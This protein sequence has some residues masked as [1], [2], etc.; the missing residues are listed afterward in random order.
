M[1]KVLMTGGAGFVGH[2]VVEHILKNTDFEVVCLDRLDTSGTIARLQQVLENLPAE[3]GRVRFVFHDLK[4]EINEFVAGQLG[5]P[6]YILHLAAGSHVD[7]SIEDPMSFV[8][9]NVVGTT[10]L[11]NYARQLD[12]LDLFVNFST[13]EVFGPAPQGVKYKEWDRYNSTNP[14]SGSKAGQTEMGM[15]FANTYQLPL[16]TTFCMNIFGERQHPEKYIPMCINRVLKGESITVH[17]SKE[18]DPGK[19][20]YIHARNVA[21]AV[22]F[23]LDNFEQREKYNI[24][25]EKELNNLQLAQFIAE[26]LGKE[27]KYELVD[28]HSSRPG[29]DLRYALDGSKLKDM[30]FE[31][32]ANFEQSLTKTIQ[33]TL[34]HPEWLA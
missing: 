31:Y 23:L 22:L 7:R 27:L 4:A 3:Q 34:D 11:L 19:R 28:F 24:V 14:Y 18:G 26:V 6:N 9:D 10:N 15:A 2:H 5:K 32:A 29:H 30:G 12:S 13:D 1:K 17:S 33:W 21:S 25:G 20:H 8:M 16:I